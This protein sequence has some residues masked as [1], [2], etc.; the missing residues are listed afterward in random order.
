MRSHTSPALLCPS[1]VDVDDLIYLG[2]SARACDTALPNQIGICLKVRASPQRS[3]AAATPR[4]RCRSY[5]A[6]ARAA[7]TASVTVFPC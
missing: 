1:Q 2:F 5:R 6:R 3:R 4:L 7:C